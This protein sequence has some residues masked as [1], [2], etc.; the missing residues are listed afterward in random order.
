[1]PDSV[2]PFSYE[3]FLPWYVEETSRRLRPAL[4]TVNRV[5][6]ELMTDHLVEFDRARIRLSAGR[7]KNSARVWAKLSQEKYASRVLS[8]SDVPATIDDLVGVRIVCN[9]VSDILVIQD[10][11]SNLPDNVEQADATLSVVSASENKYNDTP[12]ESGYR[13]YHINLGV[14]IGGHSQWHNVSV[15]LQVRT[16]L[17]DS[18]GELTHEDTYKPGVELPALV[19]TLAKRMSNLLSCV[20]EL[21]QDIRDELDQLARTPEEP[22]NESSEDRLNSVSGK[23]EVGGPASDLK[24]S[25][26]SEESIPEDA[27]MSET[28][29]MVRDLSKPES[30]ATIAHRLQVLFG[31]DIAR[32]SWGR[33]GSFK[34]LLME[35]VPDVEIVN[36]GP[37]MVVPNGFDSEVLLR[38]V[39]A[40]SNYG[41]DLAG[42]PAVLLTLKKYDQHVP[43]LP[44]EGIADIF[45]GM[46]LCIRESAWLELGI[47][48]STLGLKEVTQLSKYGRD[49]LHAKGIHVQRA[50]LGYLLTAMLFSGNLRPGV[51]IETIVEILR[52]HFRTRIGRNLISVTEDQWLEL[53]CWLDDS[54]EQYVES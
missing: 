51:S 4:V 34:S 22:K 45:R 27:L 43:A 33:F 32:S 18:W 12:K 14:R 40:Q 11:L 7:V 39:D 13:A 49:Q 16:L 3:E 53:D 2:L 24:G 30:M 31:Q 9:N 26:P 5:L 19:K 8:L 6:N 38:N 21:A 41:G 54:H 44:P 35:S 29:S 25:T 23:S 10:M 46:E 42:V 48:R 28:R 36:V 47:P 15:E 1:M 37:G 52:A 50:K 17:Q 20:D